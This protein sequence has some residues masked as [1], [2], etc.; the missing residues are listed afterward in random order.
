MTL[1]TVLSIDAAETLKENFNTIIN[2]QS[3]QGNVTLPSGTW[4]MGG[5]MVGNVSSG[6]TSIKFNGNGAYV[7]TPTL[8]KV[9]KIGFTYRSGG[10][11]KDITISYSTDGGVTWTA[12]ET[13]HIASSSS[14]FSGYSKKTGTEELTGVKFRIF[15][16]LRQVIAD[17]PFLKHNT[18]GMSRDL[19]PY[20]RPASTATGINSINNDTISTPSLWYS[21]SGQKMSK[22]VRGINIYNGKKHV[23]K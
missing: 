11:N 17:Y 5:G 1:L 2:G 15:D 23:V 22:P 19:G 8:D 18:T 10:S 14:S 4:Q 21:I 16:P 6:V 7:I 13:F 3:L 12:I 20:E 9:A